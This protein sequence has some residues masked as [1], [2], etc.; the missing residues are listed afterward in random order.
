[1]LVGADQGIIVQF[2]VRLMLPKMGTSCLSMMIPRR[3][4]EQLDIDRSV[5]L[6]GENAE[7]T[8]IAGNFDDNLI[9]F[10]SNGITVHG[11]TIL[12]RITTGESNGCIDGNRFLFEGNR[13]G[14]G[15]D[16]WSGCYNT[17]SNNI[18]RNTYIGISIDSGNGGALESNIV[19]NNLFISSWI[20]I[21]LDGYDD[22]YGGQIIARSNSFFNNTFM[23]NI[24]GFQ[25]GYVTDNNTISHNNFV[26]NTASADLWVGDTGIADGWVNNWTGNYWSD[27][28]GSDADGDGY[29]DTP[30]FIVQGIVD[31][32]PVMEPMAFLSPI[33]I[34]YVNAAWEENSS[35]H[36]WRT[37]QHGVDD[38][39]AGS[40]VFIFANN[41]RGS[42][43]VDASISLVGSRSGVI[44]N[45]GGSDGIVL[46][47]YDISLDRLKV[48]QASVGIMVGR[49]LGC[50]VQS[51]S[52]SD[53]AVG[54]E[55]L[56]NASLIRDSSFSKN[57]VEGIVLGT[58]T[59]RITVLNVS[60][61][62][63]PVGILQ[64]PSCTH[65]TCCPESDFLIVSSRHP[66]SGC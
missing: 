9:L 46:Q 4:D 2:R 43:V 47:A 13:Q 64:S 32:R 58:V 25:I 30:D 22:P 21:Y 51:C 35:R 17:I 14:W 59:D 27:Y 28:Y 37:I 54:I 36:I 5:Q 11:F 53:C 38:A 20:G 24:I 48:I 29:G 16:L 66:S 23:D 60:V 26:E 34:V 49:S 3:Y 39:E 1:M 45:G 61:A 62:S 42:V 8:V 40:L 10:S 15:I 18:F 65:C 19:V 6:I 56:G 63:N 50:V 41:Y 52:V 44:V 33:R 57:T 7:T 12:G 55:D 31:Y